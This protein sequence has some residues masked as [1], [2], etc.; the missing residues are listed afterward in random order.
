VRTALGRA[1][2]SVIDALPSGLDTRLGRSHAE[3]G[4]DVS[5][6]QWQQLALARAMMR[7]EPLLMVLDEPASALDAEAEHRLFAQYA[8]TATRVARE[9]G[10]ITV[11]VSHRFSTVRM[12]DLIIVIADGTIKESGTHEHLMAMRG[13]Y[14]DLYDIQAAA[15]RP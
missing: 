8:D 13:T 2:S 6:G 3:G 7:D 9:T 5:G 1:R 10:G 15:Y 14:A 4:T 12:A 11:F